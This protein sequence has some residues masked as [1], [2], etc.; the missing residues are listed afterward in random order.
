MPVTSDAGS[1]VYRYLWVTGQQASTTRATIDA[2]TPNGVNLGTL[3][4]MS[5]EFVFLS[6]LLIRY[7]T[8]NW[9]IISNTTLTG[10]RF[11]Q[12]G[13]VGS[14]LSSVS[15]DSSLTG[16]GTAADPLHVVGY[17]T[18][19]YE[20]VGSVTGTGSVQD[21]VNID[22]ETYPWIELEMYCPS[23]STASSTQLWCNADTTAANYNAE[24]VNATATTASA[25]N[26]DSSL[27]QLGSGVNPSP[28][29]MVL[30]MHALNLS[31]HRLANIQTSFVAAAGTMYLR[32]RASRWEG[33]GA[34]TKFSITA[35]SGAV[36]YYKLRARKG[37]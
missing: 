14:F 35:P 24:E 17:G 11:Q 2:E 21:L 8:G 10:S 16:V 20:A 29:K 22:G 15:T 36:W 9:T 31:V 7:A 19:Y 28:I 4:S 6:R 30:N 13:A 12:V 1:Q 34:L 27:C 37:A 25:A 32:N 23:H 33:A 18:E 3:T 26:A 5:A